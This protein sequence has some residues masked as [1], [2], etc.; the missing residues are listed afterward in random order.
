MYMASLPLARRLHSTQ[1]FCCID[2]HFVYPDGFAAVLLGKALG[3]PVIVSARG[4]DINVY[5]SLFLIRPLLRWTLTH[6]A[7]AI[8]VSADLKKKMIDQ[9]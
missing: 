1:H 8:A 4:T 6:A 3:L 9:H 7:G 5:P 2:A